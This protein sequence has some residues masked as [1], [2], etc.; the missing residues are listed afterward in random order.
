MTDPRSSYA[1]RKIRRVVLNRPESRYCGIC[2]AAIDYHARPRSTWAPSVDHII[3]VDAGGSHY[4]LA[5][6]RAV[7][8]GCNSRKRDRPATPDA[9][10]RDW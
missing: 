8:C 7:H 1:W 6:L 9:P 10:R 3:G 5:N 4:A 2:H